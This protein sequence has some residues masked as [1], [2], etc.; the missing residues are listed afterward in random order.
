MNA[1]EALKQEILQN[2]KP[3]E[4]TGEWFVMSAPITADTIQQALAEHNNVEIPD[5]GAP[6]ELDKPIIMYSNHHLRVAKNQVITKVD[7][8]NY[9]LL[10]NASLKDG[11]FGPVS[12][13]R[14]HNI[15]I[16]GG[17]W[18]DKRSRCAINKE[19]TVR[20]SRGL[21]ILV[22]IEQVWVHDLTVRESN[23]YGVQICECR[24]F[25]VENLFFDNH[26]KDGVHVN[27]P[28]TYGTVRHLSGAHMDDDMVALNAWDWYASA[29]T[30]GTIDH[31]VIEDI[32]R[33]DNEIRLLPGQKVYDDGT[34][35]DCDLHHCVLENISGIYTFKLYC[36]PYWRNS[37]LPK[38]D[39]SG[40]VGE[41]YDVYFKNINFL[42]VQSSGFGDMPFNGLFDIGS[43]CKNLFLEDI[44]V[45]DTIEHCKELDVSLIKVGPLA[46]TFT[47][48]SE[49]VSTWDEVFDSDAICHA[50]DIYLKNVDFA[51]QKIT[52]TAVLSKTVRMTPNPDYP[53]TTPKGG[54]G[55]GT[56]GKIV[57][58]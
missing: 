9:C 47:G 25:I 36:Q 16:E 8:S 53:K 11:A 49:D 43:N 17:I 50:T 3:V 7:G 10:R 4:I 45:A 14:D 2:I 32:K 20:G 55:Y 33:N 22:C 24:D 38:P 1:R 12:K 6:I 44:H 39:F 18:D 41:I 46:Y 29:I 54:T 27:G 35:V 48:G 58:E 31:L 56:L 37:L 26:H 40:T 28:A 57:A 21:I 19:D 15:S 34:K 51:G 42:A 13:E 23:N 30:Y 52:D 5:I